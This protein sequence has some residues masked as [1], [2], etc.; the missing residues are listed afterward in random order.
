[1]EESKSM[2]CSMCGKPLEVGSD[3]MQIRSG[4]INT[5]GEFEPDEDIANIHSKPCADKMLIL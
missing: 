1:V 5:D 4:Y 2:K 3:V